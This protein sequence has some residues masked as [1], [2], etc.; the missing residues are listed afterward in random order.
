MIFV[1]T[2][3]GLAAANAAT[4]GGPKIEI[5]TYK[6][7]AGVAYTPVIEDTALHGTILH[8]AAPSNYSVLSANAVQYLLT[9][10]DTIG[11]FSFGEIGLYLADGTLFAL[12]ALTQ[13]QQKT[14]TSGITPGN[15]IQIDARLNLS[16]VS[17]IISFPITTLV[18]GKIPEIASVDL[19]TT[20]VLSQANV[21]LV[22][23]GDET[24]TP[25]LAIRND[26][27]NWR[28]MTH[29]TRIIAS[30]LVGTGQHVSTAV[31][32]AAGLGYA[33][34]DVLTV[35]GG[36]Y[37]VPAQFTV[38]SVS[39]SGAVTGLAITEDGVYSV[40]PA[41]PVSLTGG[42]GNGAV[43]ATTTYG[44]A[45]TL[46]EIV[47]TSIGSKLV[48]VQAG[49]YIMEITSGV[50]IGSCRYVT[51]SKNNMMKWAT[52]LASVPLTSVTFDVY[53][54]NSSVTSSM[55]NVIE[56]AFVNSLIF[57]G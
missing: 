1:I 43:T 3:A 33:V 23:S 5:T 26:D 19:L 21:Y 27:T 46:H 24:G 31:V 16:Q 56:E 30:G 54:S 51:I 40:N 6:V 57:G 7:G 38:T 28:F 50:L 42:T 17:A 37:Y 48:D 35:I 53:Q 29:N 10:D 12:S 13:V 15:I 14:A 9:M 2:N 11:N 22:H 4:A 47:S 52:D 32:A 20:P 36:T 49:Q 8:T 34:N 45:N 25:T 55:S 39:G 41:S 44:N 18:N